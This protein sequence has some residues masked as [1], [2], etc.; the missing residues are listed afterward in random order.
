[1]DL[2]NNVNQG[3]SM[4]HSETIC[5]NSMWARA[6]IPTAPLPIQQH[7]NDPGKEAKK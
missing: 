4:W 1:M 5:W 3:Q 7:A 6:Q 2:E